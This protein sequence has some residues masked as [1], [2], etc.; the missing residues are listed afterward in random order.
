MELADV[1]DSKSRGSDTVWVRPPPPAPE[2][3]I[4]TLYQL[5][6]GSDLLIIEGSEA[7]KTQVCFLQCRRFCESN[8]KGE[9][10]M[11][12]EIMVKVCSKCGIAN[13]EKAEECEACGAELGE[14]IT[15]KEAKKLS[16]Q[17]AK[18]N[19]K[20]KNAIAAEKFG[21]QDE[22]DPIDIPV[23]PAHIVI[24][25][26]GC[27]AAVCEIVIM[28]LSNKLF[29]EYTYEMMLG[30]IGALVLLAV[31]ILD[32]FMPSMMWTLGH[33]MDRFTTRKCQDL[34]TSVLCFR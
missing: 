29:P 8:C 14:P 12:K 32:C 26:I 5:V 27:L 13:P 16:K 33:Y 24:G 21:G 2:R 25:V 18:K 22:E 1:R 15:N 11:A 17:I 28:V 10:I 3:Q 23:T 6:M 4:R 20:F 9:A 34:R 30:G 7:Y 31:A 19:E